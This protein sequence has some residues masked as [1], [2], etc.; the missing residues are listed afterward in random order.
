MFF[1]FPPL[2]TINSCEQI[3]KRSSSKNSL[4]RICCSIRDTPS[5]LIEYLVVNSSKNRGCWLPEDA[6]DL[7]SFVVMKR[8]RIE[9]AKIKI[10]SVGKKG[11]FKDSLQQEVNSTDPTEKMSEY[12][13]RTGSSSISHKEPRTAKTLLDQATVSDATASQVLEDHFMSKLRNFLSKHHADAQTLFE[14]IHDA[15]LHLEEMNKLRRHNRKLI[16]AVNTNLQQM[17]SRLWM[18]DDVISSKMMEAEHFAKLK[19][20]EKLSFQQANNGIIPYGVMNRQAVSDAEVL[21]EEAYLKHQRETKNLLAVSAEAGLKSVPEDT[22]NTV[23]ANNLRSMQSANAALINAK[24]PK[25]WTELDIVQK[26]KN[27]EALAIQWHIS[28]RCI[29]QPSK[30][31]TPNQHSLP[32]ANKVVQQYSGYYPMPNT[33]FTE[34]VQPTILSH[35]PQDKQSYQAFVHTSSHQLGQ[36]NRPTPQSG[37]QHYEHQALE[38][39]PSFSSPIASQQTSAAQVYARYQNH[40]Q[41]FSHFLQNSNMHHMNLAS[42]NPVGR[43][44]HNYMVP[45]HNALQQQQQQ[46]RFQQMQLQQ[47]G[48][49]LG[50]STMMQQQ[51][52]SAQQPYIIMQSRPP[53]LHQ[54]SEYP[55]SSYPG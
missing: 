12:V 7:Q 10:D 5:G 27:A 35:H 42:N 45:S 34:L 43:S 14:T 29:K 53:M 47:Q 54:P 38:A 44:R 30:S 36:Q 51:Q 39:P 26:L 33:T 25:A 49:I 48:M 19:V 46:R 3:T 13:S 40:T 11:S 4:Y 20:E 23:R 9:R 55:S 24:S 31:P 37:P 2:K 41:G 18:A 16:D 6:I 32:E 52:P 21:L 8:D 1:L 15:N 50:N 17:G 28:E 22:M